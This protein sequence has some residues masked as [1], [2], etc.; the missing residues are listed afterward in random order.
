MMMVRTMV[1]IK[2]A[3]TRYGSSWLELPRSR[4][5]SEMMRAIDVLQSKGWKRQHA[6]SRKGGTG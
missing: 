5:V 3:K 1:T 6:Q 4:N 2:M